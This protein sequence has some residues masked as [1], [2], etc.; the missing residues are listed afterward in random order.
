MLQIRKS[1]FETNSSS[2]HSFTLKKEII[3]EEIDFKSE[4]I[5]I[6]SEKNIIINFIENNSCRSIVYYEGFSSKLSYILLLL[7]NG[8][9][10]TLDYKDIEYTLVKDLFNFDIFKPL[11]KVIKEL[12]YKGIK[13]ERNL[14]VLDEDEKLMPFYIDEIIY[15]RAIYLDSDNFIRN[16]EELEE[17]FELSLKEILTNDEITL[18]EMDRNDEDRMEYTYHSKYIYKKMKEKENETN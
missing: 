8:L 9:D 14:D 16:I 4:E 10:V 7:I 11:E 15:G 1:V 13:I 5:K 2:T 17:K 12:G 3:N 6:D 18:V